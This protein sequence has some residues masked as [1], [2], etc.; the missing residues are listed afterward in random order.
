MPSPSQWTDRGDGF[1]VEFEEDEKLPLELLE[2]V[3]PI[4]LGGILEKRQTTIDRKLVAVKKMPTHQNEALNITPNT[5]VEILRSL[6][7]YHCVRILGCYTQGDFFNIVM[8]PYAICDL[9]TY[10]SQSSNLGIKEVETRCGPRASLL[11][12]IMGCLAH[13]LQY[14]H[15]GPR[16]QH[17]CGEEEMIRHRDITLGNI[18]L[19]GP[20]I[21]YT[22]FGLSKICTATQTGSTGPS[23][24]TN[25]VEINLE[26]RSFLY[27]DYA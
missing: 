22:D 4:S 21:L 13:G 17:N 24:K 6:K 20:R 25:M 5:E 12:R 11:P 16:V 10:L 19:D 9:N 14:I 23:R 26:P 7:H 3:A 2:S 1:Y 27:A 18:L 8:E 15:Y